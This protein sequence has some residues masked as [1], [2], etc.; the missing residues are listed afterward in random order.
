MKKQSYSSKYSEKINKFQI[1]LKNLMHLQ[2]FKHFF[3]IKKIQ[4][5]AKNIIFDHTENKPFTLLLE[6]IMPFPLHYIPVHKL[7]NEKLMN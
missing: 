3:C 1:L 4:R 6:N 5:K 2:I 7:L